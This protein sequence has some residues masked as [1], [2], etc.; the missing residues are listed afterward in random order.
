MRPVAPGF[1]KQRGPNGFDHGVNFLQYLI[2][3]EPEDSET[4]LL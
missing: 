2:V 1:F 4:S 3:P